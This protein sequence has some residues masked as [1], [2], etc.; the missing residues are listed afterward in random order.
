MSLTV[1][2]CMVFD[3]RKFAVR[4]DA[5]IVARGFSNAG[6]GRAVCPRSGRVL[7]LRWLRGKSLPS[8]EAVFLLAQT[9]CVSADW[10]LGLSELDGVDLAA[11]HGAGDPRRVRPVASE[12]A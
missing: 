2:N 9:L 7:V 11:F 3:K 4:L 5:A 6:L 10:L 1:T 12:A 8:A